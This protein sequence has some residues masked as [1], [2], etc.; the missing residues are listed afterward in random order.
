MEKRARRL[1]VRSIWCRNAKGLQLRCLRTQKK[2]RIENSQP[3][4]LAALTA[5]TNASLS[6]PLPVP[7]S[8]PPEITV[9]EPLSTA[10][11]IANRRLE[12]CKTGAYLC[13]GAATGGQLASLA[14]PR[15]CRQ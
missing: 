10:T 1:I 2:R 15:S 4:P 9:H 5:A 12:C 3:Q 7:P 11:G 13:G 6:L 14:P 8:P